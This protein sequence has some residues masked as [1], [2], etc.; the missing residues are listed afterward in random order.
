M[1]LLF[2]GRAVG[3][4]AGPLPFTRRVQ[5]WVLTHLRQAITSLGE[6]WR[7]PLWAIITILVLG[8][9]MTLPTTLY[10]LVK[11]LQQVSASYDQSY[12]IS[13]FLTQDTTATDVATLLTILQADPAVANVR[14]I[15]K[16]SAMAEF[17]QQSGFGE[18]LA[19]LD[20]NPLPDVLLVTP[21]V[22]QPAAAEALLLKLQ[23]ERWVE[24][25][26]LDISWLQRLAALTALLQQTVYSLAVLL[27]T[28]A[29]LVIGNT[30][31]LAIVD[32]KA[33]IEVMKLVG[34]TDA[35][36]QRPFLYTGLWLGL[37]GGV[38]AYIVVELLLWWLS[39]GIQHVTALYQSDFLLTS[40]ELSEFGYLLAIA[41]TLGLLG[42]Y[43]AVRSQLRAI[44]PG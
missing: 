7:A 23:Q 5:R 32:K 14:F 15:D 41:V 35:F 44:S 26:K 39:K 4:D 10:V 3:A 37:F 42:S 1:S 28:A 20:E 21:K 38:V 8:I 40:L 25:A 2:S 12:E 31:R 22:N 30:I 27:L 16:A 17:K 18:A 11:N 29:L 34:A 9:S 33:E 36:I 24:L 19:F 43:L 13:L 6:I